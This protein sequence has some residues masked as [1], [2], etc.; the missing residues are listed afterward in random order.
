MENIEKLSQRK[1]DIETMDRSV[2]ADISQIQINKKTDQEEK[3]E[4][5]TEQIRNPYCFL[6]GK[7]PVRLRFSHNGPE[8]AELLKQFFI[9]E[10]KG[11]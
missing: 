1:E 9:L 11:R 2:L 7:T 8:L 10:G 3:I 6:C 5:F 4:Q